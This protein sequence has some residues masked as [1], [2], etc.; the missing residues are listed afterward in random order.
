[1]TRILKSQK[2]LS[3]GQVFGSR[4]GHPTSW[5]GPCLAGILFVE[6]NEPNRGSRSCRRERQG[7]AIAIAVEGWLAVEMATILKDMSLPVEL[8]RL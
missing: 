2:L 5:S 8:P 1:M 7:Y 4:S 3:L 6:V